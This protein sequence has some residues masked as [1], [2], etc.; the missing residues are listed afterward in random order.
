MPGDD[1]QTLEQK[2]QARLTAQ[3]GFLQMAGRAAPSQPAPGGAPAGTPPSG[4]PDAAAPVR[5][6]SIQ[7]ARRLKPGTWFITPTGEKL[8]SNGA[9]YN[10]R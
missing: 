3:Q 1:P 5:V 8:Q 10:G 4:Q 9:E 2:R 6:R 7:E